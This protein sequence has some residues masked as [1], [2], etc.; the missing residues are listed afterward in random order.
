MSATSFKKGEKA[1]VK[2]RINGHEFKI[3]VTVVIEDKSEAD[4]RCRY[5]NDCWWLDDSELSK[6][7]NIEM[8][9]TR[10]CN[11]KDNAIFYLSKERKATTYKL[12]KLDGK[13][14]T[15]TYQSN[16]STRTSTRSWDLVCLVR[17]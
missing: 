17:K 5:R 16:T 2:K 13:A 8:K 4:Y 9:K 6:L 3:G 1:V 12:L 15:A 10:L 14:K 11:L 7:K